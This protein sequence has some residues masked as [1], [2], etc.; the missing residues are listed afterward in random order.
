VKIDVTPLVSV[1]MPVHNSEVYLRDSV[2]SV[3][4]QSVE[5]L[6]L[7][8][9]DDA[10]TDHSLAILNEIASLDP[11]VVCIALEDNRGAAQAR[12]VAL[13][14]AH[15]LYVAFLDSDDYWEPEKLEKQLKIM[16]ITDCSICTCGYRMHYEDSN[17]RNSDR[18]FHVLTRITYE[19]LLRVNYF[20]CSTLV[21]NRKLV[22]KDMFD[23][24]L[25]H[26]DYGAWLSLMKNG[27]VACGIDE[28]LATYRI[29]EGSRSHN[30]VSAARGRWVALAECT[31]E[32]LMKRII[33][34]IQYAISG[35]RKYGSRYE[36]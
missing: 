30:K 15:G 4:G 31:D 16:E 5:N 28:P 10:S 22:P 2:S 32:T 33:L 34:F 17:K 9:V 18:I 6:E 1:I 21:L 13:A 11:R 3:L 36:E 23:S 26:E 27:R 14:N 19:D 20:S 7:I 8:V 29:R 35:V 24:S 12:N 25:V